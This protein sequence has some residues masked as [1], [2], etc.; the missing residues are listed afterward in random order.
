[1]S[2][3]AKKHLSIFR[4]LYG[5]NNLGHVRIVTTD[6]SRVGEQEG[7]D[8]E[9]AL[10]KGAFKH[11]V[12]AGAVM[13]RHDKGRESALSIMSQLV[14]K[15]LVIVQIQEEL[16]AGRALGGTSAGAVI[17]ADMKELQKKHKKEISHLEKEIEQAT[18]DND[19]ELRDELAEDR[20]QLE[21]IMA[22]AEEDWKRL[23]TT[24]QEARIKR[25]ADMRAT[26]EGGYLFR[27][28][29]EKQGWENPYS[30]ES[31]AQ[32]ERELE[33]ERQPEQKDLEK[34]GTMGTLKRL[35]KR[36]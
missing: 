32:L 31:L 20:R 28:E 16:D 18:L 12:K 36:C 26:N 10:A 15:Q 4:E 6:W 24:L 34:K 27:L 9:R 2:G 22:R 21:Q 5:N 3:M 1:M 19:E 8:R 14:H 23:A 11:L 30:I 33:G 17:I 29:Q 25:E 7:R 13:A 35:K